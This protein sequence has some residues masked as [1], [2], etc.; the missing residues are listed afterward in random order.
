MKKM[1]KRIKKRTKKKRMEKPEQQHITL[2]RKA[3][4]DPFA[5]FSKHG[6]YSIVGDNDKVFHN[7]GGE[8]FD[9]LVGPDVRLNERLHKAAKLG[10]LK[11][12]KR[13]LEYGANI[14]S[15][16]H[17]LGWTALHYAAHN[18]HEDLVRFL[19][20]DANANTEAKT[21]DGKIPKDL[22][23]LG[24]TY[25]FLH[26]WE[27]EVARRKRQAVNDILKRSKMKARVNTRNKKKQQQQQQQR[28]NDLTHKDNKIIEMND[29]EHFVI[30]GEHNTI[31][32]MVQHNHHTNTL[33]N[34]NNND[35]T[36]GA[37]NNIID[38]TMV[39]EDII[40]NNSSY[41]KQIIVEPNS[42]HHNMID[43]K[44]M[45]A[46]QRRAIF[47]VE[48]LCDT[49]NEKMRQSAANNDVQK[50]NK[51]LGSGINC[52]PQS[53]LTGWAPIH[54]A[55][56]SNN[57]ECVKILLE[58]GSNPERKTSDGKTAIHLC[59]EG[60]GERHCESYQLIHKWIDKKHTD[61]KYRNKK[62]RLRR[63]NSSI[64]NL[65]LARSGFKQRSAWR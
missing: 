39:V 5:Y 17:V 53:K 22:C 21:F 33:S 58:H 6:P 28:V 35:M 14:D 44:N 15:R 23:D 48:I 59:L 61:E 60:N 25:T 18:E 62:S 55:A 27:K 40:N 13:C 8:Y 29:N 4:S 50:L 12:V 37:N 9:D 10:K 31:E 7:I 52:D 64:E 45:S 24:N 65:S 36:N 16:N 49:I 47:S 46:T 30:T 11:I 19:A 26:R 41:E 1:K 32:K 54:Y 63:S 20:I 51:L 38:N 2:P 56:Y 43:L 57:H 34:N 42:N 3:R